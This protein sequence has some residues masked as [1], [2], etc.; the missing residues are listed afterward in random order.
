MNDEQ[1]R[2]YV[3]DLEPDD[4]DSIREAVRMQFG[5]DYCII[6]AHVAFRLMTTAYG[7]STK[8][9]SL[10]VAGCDLLGRLLGSE[11]K[12]AIIGAGFGAEDVFDIIKALV[13]D[14]KENHD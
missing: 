6:S 9:S 10:D 12:P 1:V 3:D 8:T 7:L 2:K 4:M 14:A 5:D 13:G 11:M